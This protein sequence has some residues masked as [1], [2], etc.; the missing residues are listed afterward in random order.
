MHRGIVRVAVMVVFAGFAAS[1]AGV[2]QV[3]VLASPTGQR[4]VGYWRTTLETDRPDDRAPVSS[5]GRRRLLIE[6]WYPAPGERSTAR[7]RRYTSPAIE[8]TLVAQ[9]GL[10]PGWAGR[11]ATHAVENAAA[12]PGPHPV[13]IF[14]HGLSWPVSL[15]QSFTEELASHG[16]VVIGINHP[17]GTVI[18]FGSGLVV[19]VAELPEFPDDST[20][21]AFLARL[22]GV[23]KEDIRTVIE[24]LPRWNAEG[25]A[26]LSGGLD[27]SR[28]AL[29]GHSLGG[30]A[31]A[32]L[33]DDP[34][35]KAVVALEG[36]F[37]GE[38]A[39]SLTVQA[40]F[41][42]LIGEYNRTELENRN[43]RP[44]D[45][46]PVYQAVIAGTGHA[47]FSDLIAIYKTTA[48]PDWLVRHRYELEPGRIIQITR[49]YVRAFLGRYLLDTDNSLLHPT[50]YAARVDGPRSAGYAEVRLSIDAH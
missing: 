38:S 43:Y 17:H 13:V 28:L 48:P 36:K 24:Q 31:A 5:P 16:Y 10:T 37:R 7:A 41:L 8:S 4:A 39:A 34:R 27:T 26:P 22:T 45:R 33:S 49:D 23:W 3:E 47:S 20:G 29:V 19:P 2:T 9:L 21:H 14:S 11:V 18:D 32:L 15:Y 25:P 30:S 44:S 42:H 1:S 6:V 46:A 50:G 12:S 35:V 40:P